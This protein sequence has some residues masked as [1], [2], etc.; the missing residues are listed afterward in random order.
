MKISTGN[1]ISPSIIR[2][3]LKHLPDKDIKGLKEIKVML[4]PPI[5]QQR[6][7]GLGDY[8][9]PEQQIR[10]FL[11]S[12][13]ESVV[14]S[15]TSDNNYYHSFLSQIASTLY[16]EVGHHVDYRYGS[17]KK[18][19]KREE[20]LEKKKDKIKDYKCDKY[21][22]LSKELYGIHTKI[23]K[24]ASDY[25][26]KY[27]SKYNPKLPSFKKIAFIKI[28]REKLVNSMMNSLRE[29]SHFSYH[30]MAIV[31][32]LRKCKLSKYS[33]Y[34]ITE[35][36]EKLNNYFHS[37]RKLRQ[38]YRKKVKA[39]CLKIEK[40]L[41]Y[42]SKHNRKYAYFTI[43]QVNRLIKN[44][45]L[46][47]IMKEHNLISEKIEKVETLERELNWARNELAEVS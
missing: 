13:K 20:S 43:Q 14:R 45:S 9:F 15:I 31:E 21:S 30:Q 33:L 41:Y 32:H 25:S 27:I 26:D 12:T 8:H 36:C 29:R 23:E 22:S 24:F 42:T 10:I 28:Y 37:N 7:Y 17:L 19:S 46:K 16:H 6:R 38:K 2:G 11:W 44:D 1:L 34:S 47:E 5:K 3:M 39:I 4:R 40:P 35:I 18:Q